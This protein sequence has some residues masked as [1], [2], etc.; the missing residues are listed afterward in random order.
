M[1]KYYK[2]VHL[3]F[4]ITSNNLVHRRGLGFTR[5]MA[6]I[7][8]H[9]DFKFLS[10]GQ[11]IVQ[12]YVLKMDIWESKIRDQASRGSKEERMGIPARLGVF[13]NKRQSES[14]D[15]SRSG[16]TGFRSQPVTEA[17]LDGRSEVVGKV[18]CMI[19]ELRFGLKSGVP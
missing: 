11:D 7:D 15:R 19:L 13:K 8:E 18:G 17:E 1:C 5:V 4:K 3:D 10:G 12:Y 14:E 6:Q 2:S 9:C 16:T